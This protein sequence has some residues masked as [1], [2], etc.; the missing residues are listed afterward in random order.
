M[1]A[2]D[3]QVD[4]AH[5][6]GRKIQPVEY[7]HANGLG[8]IEGSVVKYITRFREKNGVQDLLK[9]KHYVDLLIELEYSE[10]EHENAA[11]RTTKST[12]RRNKRRRIVRPAIGRGAR[13][14]RVAKSTRVTGRKSTTSAR[15]RREVRTPAATRG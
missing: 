6:K 1:R 5:Y 15:Y 13:R 11:P 4:G 14:K 10:W 9:I 8:F 7:I 12:T 3:V 2:L